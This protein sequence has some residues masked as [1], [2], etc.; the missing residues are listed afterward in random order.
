M[1]ELTDVRYEVD[2]GLAWITIDRPDRLNAF[3]ARTVDELIRCFKRAWASSEVGVVCLTGAGERALLYGR[4]PEAASRE[5]RLRPVRVG[6]F[7][8]RVPPPAD[9]RGTKAGDRGGQRLCDRRRARPARAV[10][11]HDRCRH[12]RLRPDRPSRRLVRRRLRHRL[13]R[14]RHPRE[15]RA[16][17]LVALPPL[18]RRDRRTLGTGKPRRPRCP[19]C[20]PRSAAGRTRSEAA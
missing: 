20:A 13:S 9:S 8:D 7:R 17:D 2:D 11:P 5:R 14:P 10:R 18:Q 6:P 12:C 16:R 1:D 19:V 4:R 3:R 15:T